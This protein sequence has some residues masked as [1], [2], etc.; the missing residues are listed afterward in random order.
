MRPWQILERRPLLDR[1][2]WF[3]MWE[4]D[5]RLPGGHTIPG[6][7]CSETRE[8]AMV[9]A[10]MCDGTVP[11]VRQYKHGKGR[12]SLD[13]PAGYLDGPDEAPLAAAQRELR[14]E[15][16]VTAGRWRPMGSFVLDANRGG[17]RMHLFL[18]E[19][20]R[21]DGQQ[22]LDVTEDLE[23]TFHT[24]R[25][26][27]RHGALGAHRQPARRRRGS[28]WR[29]SI[30]GARGERAA[31]RRRRRQDASERV[32]LSRGLSS[33]ARPRPGIRWRAATG[34]A[35]GGTGS[36]SR[37]TSATAPVPAMPA[38]TG[39][40]TRRTLTWRRPC[41]TNAHRMGVE[42]ARIEPREGEWSGEAVTHYRDVLKALR[43][44]GIAPM[45]T[46]HHFRE[47]ALAGRPRRLGEPR[48]GGP[49]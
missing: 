40:A 38:I 9:F 42:W 33:G 28:C 44:R 22:E 32:P 41:T 6:Y 27:D 21:R 36:S 2:P 15:T 14:E 39:T 11:L 46:L 37:A 4:E 49:L 16:G 12:D 48:R 25:G 17:S 18:A 30:L 24:V 5:V 34:R 35:T 23:V 19:D 7:L 20:A 1:P 13:L 45:V 8:Y 29:P 26:V 3:R 31:R 47:P 10:L 43:E